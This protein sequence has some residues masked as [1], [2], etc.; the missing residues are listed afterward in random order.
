M[1]GFA[2]GLALKDGQKVTQKSHILLLPKPGIWSNYYE[3]KSRTVTLRAQNISLNGHLLL[4]RS[5]ISVEHSL[6]IHW[7]VLLWDKQSGPPTKHWWMSRWIATPP[8]TEDRREFI[9]LQTKPKGV[10]T[11][12]KALDEYILMVLFVSL[13]KRVHFLVSET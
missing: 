10:T 7:A 4:S 6:K 8:I 12:M 13:L 11:Q 9:F 2:P 3:T 1:K 5:L